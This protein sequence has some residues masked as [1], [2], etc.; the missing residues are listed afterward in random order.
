M[1]CNLLNVACLLHRIW[2]KKYGKNTYRIEKQHEQET[3]ETLSKAYPNAGRGGGGDE[4]DL[5]LVA[6]MVMR[7]H[8]FTLW[9]EDVEIMDLQMRMRMQQVRCLR[10]SRPSLDPTNTNRTRGR[11]SWQTAPVH[12]FCQGRWITFR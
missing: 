12:P 8:Q 3:Q 4:V 6:V 1:N 11:Q 5:K 10:E 9:G 2:E 7:H